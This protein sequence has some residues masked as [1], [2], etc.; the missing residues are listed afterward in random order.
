MDVILRV[1]IQPK[2]ADPEYLKKPDY[3]KVPDYLKAVREEISAENSLIDEFVKKQMMTLEDAPTMCS[4]MD[5]EEREEVV[6]RLKSKWDAVNKKYQVL[7]MHTIFEGGK[8]A[9]KE[10]MEKEMNLLEA[11]LASMQGK[12]PVVISNE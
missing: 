9:L 10:T 3:G 4:L 7:C 8:K 6:A 11:D 12:G 1:P 5:E 2:S